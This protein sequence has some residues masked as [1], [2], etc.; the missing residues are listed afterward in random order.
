MGANDSLIAVRVV[1]SRREGNTIYGRTLA[2]DEP[3][4]DQP[5]VFNPYAGEELHFDTLSCATLP[6]GPGPARQAR[7]GRIFPDL[8]HNLD[9][10][11]G[12]NSY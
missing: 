8:Q 2:P 5:V 1:L 3:D 9:L 11:Y 12:G 7:A 4:T 6:E 10:A